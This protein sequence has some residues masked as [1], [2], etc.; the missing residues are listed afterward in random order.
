MQVKVILYGMELF[1]CVKRE[2]EEATAEDASNCCHLSMFD[3]IHN[4]THYVSYSYFRNSINIF[5][6][7]VTDIFLFFIFAIKS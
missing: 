1:D 2:K 3:I 4:L 5:F 7:L 6:P